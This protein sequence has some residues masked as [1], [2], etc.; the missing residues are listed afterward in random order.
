MRENEKA[1]VLEIGS[2]DWDLEDI[3]SVASGHK[4]LEAGDKVWCS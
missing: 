4:N 2:S 3:L 1:D